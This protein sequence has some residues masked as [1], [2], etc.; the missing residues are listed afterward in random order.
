MIVWSISKSKYQRVLTPWWWTILF[1]TNRLKRR[2]FNNNLR[3]GSFSSSF[4]VFV[5]AAQTCTRSGLR[6]RPHLTFK[7]NQRRL[8]F[9]YKVF[10]VSRIQMK[11]QRAPHRRVV[12]AHP[13]PTMRMGYRGFFFPLTVGAAAWLDPYREEEKRAAAH[14]SSPS[15]CERS[16]VVVFWTDVLTKKGL[17]QYKSSY[18]Q[19]HLLSITRSTV[20]GLSDQSCE[21]MRRVAKTPLCRWCV[22][23]GVGGGCSVSSTNDLTVVVSNKGEVSNCK[24]IYPW[25]G[26]SNISILYLYFL[27][28]NKGGKW[29]FIVN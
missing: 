20:K 13:H 12:G 10:F 27:H 19:N 17:L 21:N 8:C 5:G 4:C 29:L 23:G 7:C 18:L 14:M 6:F 2:K 26:L 11:R 16:S 24:M 25:L 15:R 9:N 22:W 28:K 1:L 3:P